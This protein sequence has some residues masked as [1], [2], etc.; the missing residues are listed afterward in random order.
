[1]TFT[2]KMQ[3]ALWYW[4]SAQ[5]TNIW[6]ESDLWMMS[7]KKRQHFAQWQY[8]FNVDSTRM[9][10]LHAIYAAMT[11]FANWE[12]DHLVCSAILEYMVWFKSL[13]V[14][15]QYSFLVII[16]SFAT[17]SH[18]D[19]QIQVKFPSHNFPTLVKQI[20]FLWAVF[21]CATQITTTE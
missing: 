8:L 13:S 12:D 16:Y 20:T 15:K 6:K 3:E 2:F 4:A 17:L 11:L 14:V 18:C 19:K 10:T 21:S 1:M 9:S 5:A 7:Q